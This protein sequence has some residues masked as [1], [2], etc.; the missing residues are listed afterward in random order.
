MAATGTSVTDGTDSTAYGADGMTITGGPSVTSGGIDAAGNTI[1]GVADGA[2]NS[3]SSDAI[4][5]SQLQAA[6]DSLASNVL[7]GN[8]DYTGNDFTM[9]DVG[10]TGEDTIDEAIASA[11]TAANAGWNVTDANGNSHNIGPN[12]EVAFTGDGNIG[13]AQTGI[14][15][16]GEVEITLNRD[17]DLDSVTTGDTAMDDS[18][19]QVGDATG[20]DPNT[21]VGAGE[22]TVAGSGTDPNT[23]S[24]NGDAGDVTGLANT[25]LDGADFAQAGRAATEEQLD[26]VNQTASAGWNLSGSGADQVNI[27]PNGNVDFQGDGN[28]SVAQS[29]VEDGGQID[30][31]LN[32]DLDVDSVTTGNTLVNDDGLTV[33]DGAGNLTTVTN[34][35]LTIAGGPSVTSGGIDAAGNTITGVADGAINSTSSDAINGS[36]LQA[37]GD[38]LASNVLGGNADYTGNDFTMSDVGGTGEDTIDEAIASANTAAN[39]G[40]D[41]SAQ[42]SNPTNVG[43]GDS[44][45]LNNSDGN[46]EVS[47]TTTDND[48]TFDLADDIDVAS[49]TADDGAGNVTAVTA[50]GTSVTDGTDSTAYGA[51]GMT[52]TGGP[53]VT[54]GGIDAGDQV[55]ANVADGDVNATSG[56]AINGSQLQA[57]GDSLAS[58]VLG[59]NADY[60]GNDFTMSDVGGT[61]EDTIDEAIA[62]ANTAA[63]A[64]WNVADANG[65]SHNIGPNGQV[66]FEGDSNVTVTESGVDDDAKVQVAL[67]DDITVDSVAADSVTTGNSTLDTDGLTV[68]DGAGNVTEVAATGTSVTDGTDSTAYGA[69]GMT[70]TGGPSVTSGGIDAGDQVIANVADGDVNATSSDA[71]N[72]SQL[73]AAGDSLASN[74]LGGNADYTGNDFTMSDVGGTGEDTIDEAIASANTAANAGWDIS[75]QGSNPTNVGPGDS[76]DLNNS[77]GNIEVSK[78]T[79]DND[80]TFDLADDIDVASVTADDGAGNVTAVTATGTSVTDG[81][82]STAYGADGMTITGGPS[83]T[84][85]GIDAGDQV[86]ANVADGDVNAT[87]G[88]AINGSQ[89]QA[90]GDSLASNVLGGNADYTGNDFTMSDVGGT[91]EDTIDEAIAS[92]NTAAN[93]GWNVADANGNSHNIGP[94]GQVTFEGDSNVTVTESGVDDDAKV[95]VALNDDITVDSVAAD[96]VT[97]GNST[98]DTDGLTVD[99]GAGNVTEVA[100]TGTSVTDGT[101]STAYGADG[102]TITGGPSVTSGGIDAGDQ[103]IANVAD[104]V[105]DSD[106][107]NVSQ[108]SGLADTPLTFA[109]DSGSNVERKLGETLNLVG[110]ETDETALV[111]GNIGVVADGS[112]TLSIQLAENV[113]LGE[114]GSVT[115]GNTLVNDDGLT[116]DDGAGNLTTV[117]NDGLAIAGGPSVTSGGIDAAGNTITGV[118][119]GAINSTSSDA[120]NGSQLQA[121]GDSLASNVLGGNADYTGNDFTMSDV[122]GTGEDT[123]DEAIASANTAANAG[124]N[125]TDAD[126]NA[127][128]IGPNGEVAFTGDGNI[129]VAQTGIDD[130]GEVEI[131]LNRDLDL[132]SVTTGDTAM[133]DSGVQVG[134]ATGND[135]NTTVGAGEITVAGSG[136]DPNTISINGDAGDVTGLANTDLDGADFAQAGRAATEEQ[137]DLVNQ[138]A[139]AG[140]NLSGS[141]ANQVNIGPNGNVDFQGDGNISVAQSGVEDDGQIDIT[142]NPALNVDSVTTGNS[143]LDTDGLAVTDTNGNQTTTGATGTTVMDAAGNMTTVSATG[144][145]VTD[146]TDSTAYGADGMTITGGPS[147]TSGG[148]DAG[149]QVI[150]NVADGVAD[151]DAVN[152]SQLSG[153]AD[154]PLT[155][156]GDSGS[157]V[158]R[159]LGETLNLVGGETDETALVDGNIGVVADGSDTLSIQLAENVNLGETGSVTTGDTMMNNAGVNV[160]DTAG[161]TTEV[162]AGSINVTSGGNSITMDGGAGDITG[163]ANTDLDGADFAQAG[164]AATEE[165]LD[166]VNQTASAGWNLSG[167]G[168]NQVNIGPNGKVDFQGDGNISV[169]QNGAEDDGEIDITLNPDLNVDSV[170]AGDATLDTEGLVVN[171][172]TANPTATTSVEA[173]MITL[174]ANPTTGSA[175][176]IVIDANSGTVGGLTNATFDPDNFTSGQ[177]ATEDQLGQ[178]YTV[179][180]AGWSVSVDGEGAQSDGSNNV[181]PGEVVDFTSEDGNVV[182]NRDGTNLAFNLAD[183]ITLGDGETAINVDGEKGEIGVGD[184]LVNGGGVSVGDDVSLGDTGLEIAG[185]PSVTA[186]G[187]DAGGS[188]I[189]GVAAGDVSETSTDAING[190]QLYDVQQIANAGWNLTGSGANEV[191]IGPE[192]S[193]DFQG[194]SNISVVQAGTDNAGEIQVA[195]NDTITLGEGDSAITLDGTEGSIATGDT[196]MNGDGVRVG[197]DV[198]LDETGLAITGGP[199][200]TVSGINAGGM[201]ITNVG[202]GLG[203][204]SLDQISGDDLMNAVNV[205]DLQQVAGDIGDDVAAA[206]TEVTEGKNISVTES[207]GS[208]GQTIY[209]VATADEVEFDKMDVGSVTID[210]DNV[211][212]D[213]NTI[214][215]GVGRGEVSAD[216]TDAVNGGQLYDVKEEIGDINNSL[217]GGMDFAADEG[218]AVNRKLGDTVAI[219]GDNNITTRTSDDGVQVTLNQELNVDSVSAGRTT[220]SDQGVTIEGGPSMTVDGIDGGGKRV[221]NVAPGVEA[222]DAVNVGQ[223]QEL[224][225][226]FAQEINN[227]HG[228]INE[229]E[230]NANA[231]SAS[232]I[233]AS[234]VPQ[235]WMPGKSMVG[236]G[237]GTYEGETAISVGVSRLSDNGRFVIQGKVTGDS[238]SNFGAGIGAG[239]HW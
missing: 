192:G 215:A 51:D 9:S 56:D 58:N 16:E 38:S 138:T 230:K 115:T 120:I 25:D 210:K 234:T 202:S 181:G 165:Q 73:Q 200:V 32:R 143:V 157:N 89:L 19:V 67:N 46:I 141:G 106:A 42:G 55:I 211:D 101:D 185:G 48:V 125:V 87:S 206:K 28:I 232:A 99:D 65:N 69:D 44:V 182:I 103:V 15:D 213:G 105:A 12:G 159:K 71:I 100:A 222:T 151:S 81:T 24:I 18:G 239:W 104:G 134:D 68:D 195:L 41:I 235:A 225:Q 203:G 64:G 61:G 118:A 198:A 96:S 79:T 74:V 83:V 214:I 37:A 142:L 33:D 47:K 123:I 163:L 62:S 26:L 197:D 156:A 221:T 17:L 95:Q 8:A 236:V 112:D 178:V 128:N 72:G 140:W 237:T 130:E 52:I 97:T 158:E 30:I 135:P 129:G 88:D 147:V 161:N 127:A 162:S 111:D 152:V 209:E 186:G 57:A 175:N 228:R 166:L 169:A 98:L 229:V 119:D 31:T 91:G 126:N 102:M 4:N 53:S 149:D 86:I 223:M 43:P 27:G 238:Q 75:A 121:A 194:D 60:A 117:T 196:I 180:N 113:N 63:N 145:S 110:G 66:T 133:D 107:V 14:D 109:G 11:N 84:S 183:S 70:I 108:L 190:S 155:F 204:Q 205:G 224:N 93:A 226:R 187:I 114:T 184:T 7:G 153:L 212:G 217:D 137:L 191:N 76:V 188:K 34:D 220:V 227:V 23:I 45:D 77:D 22:I 85:G 2:I 231:G 167:S 122:G 168:A 176:E 90:A 219:T 13:V 20:N 218:D 59:G 78:T 136:T 94:N 160:D 233:A 6:G 36:Q 35:G 29:G 54:S 179:A 199:S 124:W 146:G 207:T 21:T 10:G 139:S 116:V 40:W 3:T 201:Q 154:T 164:R 92:A 148:I 131:T 170:T 82:D 39:A 171:D 50:T 150:A 80:V 177:A 132:D 5:G 1:T 193:V 144:T 189:T 216:S 173:G 208:D 172:S 174:A 49:V